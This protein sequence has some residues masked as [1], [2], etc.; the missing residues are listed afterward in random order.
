MDKDSKNLPAVPAAE[1]GTPRRRA[2]DVYRPEKRTGPK[3]RP[4]KQAKEVVRRPEE[5]PAPKPAEKRS[6]PP[7]TRTLLSDSFLEFGRIALAALQRRQDAEAARA[8]RKVPPVSTAVDCI[9]G[10]EVQA[11]DVLAASRLGGI[12]EHFAVYVGDGRIIHYAAES[13]DFNGRISIHEADYEAF[14]RGTQ[15]VCVIDFPNAQGGFEEPPRKGHVRATAVNESLFFD[16]I[17]DS[18]YHLNTP[19][20][21]VAR[22]RSRLG[23]ERYSLPFNNCEHFAVWCKTG[24]HE[25]HQVN[26]W[27]TLLGRW[28]ESARGKG[29]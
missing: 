3:L 22:A 21:T 4:W 15:G 2:A 8:L 24:V 14:A 19:A 1:P 7:V 23:E 28:I 26:R 18:F 5:A 25:S 12:Y 20:Q 29:K 13:G 17:R 11:G 27:L 16:V 9:D 6:G 10:M